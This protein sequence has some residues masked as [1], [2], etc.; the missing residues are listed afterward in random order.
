L[1]LAQAQQ[2]ATQAR[3][4]LHTSAQQSKA[5]GMGTTNGHAA[6]GTAAP[7]AAPAASRSSIAPVFSAKLTSTLSR[8]I[9]LARSNSPLGHNTNAANAPSPRAVAAAATELS[10]AGL[11]SSLADGSPSPPLFRPAQRLQLLTPQRHLSPPL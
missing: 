9:Q 10:P 11:A 5:H 2:K 3:E 7:T 4:L 8:L 6:T 1:E